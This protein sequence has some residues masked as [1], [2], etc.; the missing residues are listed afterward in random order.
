MKKAGERSAIAMLNCA[1][2]QGVPCMR[3]LCLAIAAVN[4]L[5]TGAVCEAFVMRHA[6]CSSMRRSQSRWL[7]A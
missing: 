5:R 1:S 6:T 7:L 4:R 3:R 2:R